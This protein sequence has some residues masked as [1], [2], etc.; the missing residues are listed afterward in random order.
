MLCVWDLVTLKLAWMPLPYFP[1]PDMV[2]QGMLDDR[3]LL[4]ESTYHSLFL[5]LSGYSLGVAAGSSAES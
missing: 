1:G 3:A 4:F 5:L 2:L